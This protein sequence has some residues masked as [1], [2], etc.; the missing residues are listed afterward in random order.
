MVMVPRFLP[1][2]AF[3]LRIDF[4]SWVSNSTVSHA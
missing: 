3:Q 1:V 2:K 4:A